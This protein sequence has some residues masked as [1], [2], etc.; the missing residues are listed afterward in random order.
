VGRTR[1]QCTKAFSFFLSL[2]AN[3]LFQDL[4]CLRGDPKN[5]R[6]EGKFVFKPKKVFWL[7]HSSVSPKGWRRNF[8]T[9]PKAP[10]TA[11]SRTPPAMSAANNQISYDSFMVSMA[12]SGGHLLLPVLQYCPQ[13]GSTWTAG[14]TNNP[15][16]IEPG[17]SLFPQHSTSPSP[18]PGSSG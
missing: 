9:C 5:S 17:N 10:K 2:N 14:M 13:T 7:G 12:K 18:F 15:S 11:K 3:T 16:C 8:L 6:W 4:T 1:L